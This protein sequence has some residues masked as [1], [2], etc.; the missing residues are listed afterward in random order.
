MSKKSKSVW[1]SKTETPKLLEKIIK[2]GRLMK[3][4]EPR[5]FL[6]RSR[7]RWRAKED[8]RAN[9]VV[10]VP[11]IR[12]GRTLSDRNGA[13]IRGSRDVKR[14]ALCDARPCEKVAAWPPIRFRKHRPKYRSPYNLTSN[15]SSLM[16]RERFSIASLLRLNVSLSLS[17]YLSYSRYSPLPFHSFSLVAA[18]RPVSRSQT[19]PGR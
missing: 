18:L 10:R 14:S 15:Y 3:T 2:V 6:D 1:L 9:G 7:W 16:P 12:A 17:L 5:G 11:V 4:E 8:A 13:I 19:S